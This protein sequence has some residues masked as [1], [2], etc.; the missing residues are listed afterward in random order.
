MSDNDTTDQGPEPL[1][2]DFQPCPE[3]CGDPL[4]VHSDDLGCWMCDCT[5]GRK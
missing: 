5:Y 1:T 2:R 4:N 3:G